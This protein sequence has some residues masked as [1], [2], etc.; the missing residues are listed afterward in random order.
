ME[1]GSCF[2]SARQAHRR[3]R[4]RQGGRVSAE[5]V[6]FSARALGR[7]PRLAAPDMRFSVRMT[8]LA[9]LR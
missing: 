4:L 2:G 3:I 8:K 5:I 9:D 1:G 6:A 7:D